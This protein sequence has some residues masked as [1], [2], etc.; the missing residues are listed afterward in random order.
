MSRVDENLLIDLEFGIKEAPNGDFQ[1]ISGISNLKQA[2]FNRLVTVKG[3]LAHRPEYG[4][5]I[6]LWQN[7]IGSID[8]QRQ[9]AL[10][11]KRQFENDKRVSKVNSISII[12][13]SVNPSIFIIQYKV[14]AVGLGE[15]SGDFQPFG[16]IEL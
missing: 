9:L 3:T 14:E 15:V 6:Q 13:D 8:K 11:I 7:N 2:L 10:E 4:V 1:T 12:P 5:G 16:D